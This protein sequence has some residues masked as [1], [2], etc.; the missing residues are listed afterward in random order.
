MALQGSGL[1]SFYKTQNKEL[2]NKKLMKKPEFKS[3]AGKIN[4]LINRY[5]NFCKD[6]LNSFQKI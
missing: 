3:F 5:A 1:I 6:F 4:I 2:R